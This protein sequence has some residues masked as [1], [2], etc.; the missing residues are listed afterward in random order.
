VIAGWPPEP[1]RATV[2]MAGLFLATRCAA[3]GEDLQ[4]GSLTAADVSAF[5]LEQSALRSAGSLGNVITALRALL[6]FLYL[7][8]YRR[9]RWRRRCPRSAPRIAR[10][11]RGH[12]GRVSC[13][14]PVCVI[15]PM[16]QS[17]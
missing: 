6:R 4:L 8:Q 16:T 7:R 2:S 5:M 9:C 14:N 10:G 15:P 11:H 1:W 12:P 13:R 3:V 17:E